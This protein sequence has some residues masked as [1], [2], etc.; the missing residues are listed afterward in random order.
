[1][2]SLCITGSILT[3]YAEEDFSNTSYWN[4]LCTNSSSLSK[5]EQASCQAYIAHMKETN[6]SLQ[7]ELDSIDAKKEE[8]SGNINVYA[9]QVNTYNTQI[10]SL[11]E[12]IDDLNIQII[13]TEKR[14]A[15]MEAT[16]KANQQLIVQKEHDIE[17]IRKRLENRMVQQQETMRLNQFIDVLMGAKS[18]SDFLRIINGIEDIT[19]SDHALQDELNKN[20]QEL[21]EMNEAL[22]KEEEELLE[23]QRH[24]DGGKA[25]LA[26]QQTQLLA[27]RY[28][29]ELIVNTYNQQ[30]KD[31]DSELKLGKDAIEAN[32]STIANINQSIEDSIETMNAT[33]TPEPTPTPSSE[34]TEVT[35]SAA[36]EEKQ[37]EEAIAVV[38]PTPEPEVE[39]A[40]PYGTPKTGDTSGNPYYGGW[41]NCTWG[42]WQLVHDTLG[43]SLP[44]WGWSTNWI[45]DAAASGYP[46][47]SEPRAPSIAVYENHVALVTQVNGEQCYIREGNY[48][49]HYMERWVSIYELP[50]TGQKC[51]GYIYL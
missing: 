10:A 34:P 49:G 22:K 33:P 36:P 8:I 42:C 23:V 2:G 26:S 31:Q 21:E 46:T 51:L 27:S 44:G 39:E 45:N 4:N 18:F 14:V 17:E 16:I 3:L 6:S 38:T 15:E 13:A 19:A 30:L 1:M 40:D 35:P 37:E 48:L 9:S 20:I 11:N 12:M 5:E 43:I 7:Q 50:W 41:S 25:T 47:G 29:A 24:L 28:E 32:Q